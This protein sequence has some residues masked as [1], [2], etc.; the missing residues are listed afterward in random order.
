P[1]VGHG[2][3]P[4]R[5]VLWPEQRVAMFPETLQRTVRPAK[6]LLR[7]HAQSLRRFC[8][9]DRLLFVADPVAALANLH[10]QILIFSQRVLAKAAALFD[11]FPSPRPDRARH[12]RNAVQTRERAPIHVL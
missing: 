3:E 5:A 12:D 7:Q 2:D 10:G 9:A 1:D 6:S 4:E 11:Q 8:P